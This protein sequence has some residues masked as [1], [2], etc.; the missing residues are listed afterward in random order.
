[1]NGNLVQTQNPK[2]LEYIL[3]DRTKGEII[4]RNGNPFKDIPFAQKHTAPPTQTDLFNESHIRIPDNPI[5]EKAA[6]RLL[7]MYQ[8]NPNIFE[9]DSKG[10]IDR[11]VF[12]EVLWRDGLQRLIPADKKA[13]Y[14]KVFNA[15]PEAE[16]ISRALRYLV[17]QDYIRL[18]A[19]VIRKAEGFRNRIAGAMK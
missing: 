4:A 7:A 15:A 3:I 11:Q 14:L 2:S 19:D 12:A 5:L 16:V 8:E 17:Q 6:N 9:G 1:M 10:E 18:K 13:E